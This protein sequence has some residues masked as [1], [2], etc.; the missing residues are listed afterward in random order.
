M[1]YSFM[2]GKCNVAKIKR[3]FIKIESERLAAYLEKTRNNYRHRI[4]YC[5]GDFR[6]AM[7]KALEIVDIELDIV[8]RESTIQ[9]MLQPEKSF[10]YNSLSSKEYLQ[11]LS[12]AITEALKLPRRKVG[13]REDLSVDDTDWYVL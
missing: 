1:N 10:I 3:D 13:L 11:D 2:M 12:D 4:A 8:P 7:E 6:T 5:I 9:S